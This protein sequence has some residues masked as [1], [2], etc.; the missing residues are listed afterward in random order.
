M[1][2]LPCE[3][4]IVVL[5]AFSMTGQSAPPTH[6]QLSWLGYAIKKCW[7]GIDDTSGQLKMEGWLYIVFTFFIPYSLRGTIALKVWEISHIGNFGGRPLAILL[8]KLG[9]RLVEF[10]LFSGM[11]QTMLAGV[12]L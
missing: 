7:L 12:S 8:C 4:R 3:H 1:A 5:V 6:L 2:Q 10:L 9:R 11:S